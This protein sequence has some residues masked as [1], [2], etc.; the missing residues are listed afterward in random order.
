[1]A[2]KLFSNINKSRV[3]EFVAGSLGDELEIVSKN[4]RFYLSHTDRTLRQSL[5]KN[6]N[7]GWYGEWFD[8]N[9]LC[10]KIAQYSLLR[11][12]DPTLCFDGW[13]KTGLSDLPSEPNELLVVRPEFSNGRGRATVILGISAVDN[14]KAM[15]I[16]EKF[17]GQISSS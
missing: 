13:A 1:M 12:I 17:P 11:K 10:S 5:A 3:S 7:I 4:R 9:R 6:A 15:A 16:L 8:S 2:R 14:A